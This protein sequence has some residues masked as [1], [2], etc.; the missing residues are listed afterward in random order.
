[1]DSQ[2][3]NMLWE[4]VPNDAGI[5]FTIVFDL[6]RVY[7]ER[8]GFSGDGGLEFVVAEGCEGVFYTRVQFRS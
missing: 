2:G 8:L 4:P 6:A 3:V 7:P 5:P 1:M